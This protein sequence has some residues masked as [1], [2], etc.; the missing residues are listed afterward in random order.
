MITL[1]PVIREYSPTPR[2][3]RAV[4]RST[5]EETALPIQP[6]IQEQ[7]EF[8]DR[9]NEENRTDGFENVSRTDLPDVAHKDCVKEV[10]AWFEEVHAERASRAADGD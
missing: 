6:T 1:L 5:T 2:A 7:A 3:R 8:Y 4:C 10:W 9:W